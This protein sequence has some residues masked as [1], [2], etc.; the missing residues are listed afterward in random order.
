MAIKGQKAQ[1]THGA[2]Q[3]RHV[4]DDYPT[5]PGFILPLLAR[6]DL[7]KTDVLWDP[8][9][10]GGHLA[11]VL[12]DSGYETKA[13]DIVYSGDDFLDPTKDYGTSDWVITN[14]PFKLGEAF[15]RKSLSVTTKGVAMLMNASFIETVGRIE[16]LYTE[17][18]PSLLLMCHRK[19]IMRDKTHSMFSHVWIIWDKTKPYTGTS[20]EYLR[21]DKAQNLVMPSGVVEGF[22]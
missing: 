12:R 22:W 16:G 18:P 19:M 4:V 2:S 11:Q 14:P 3:E 21:L 7:P 20:F 10:G 5:P 17:F 1:Y 13:N 15:V 9:A 8:C 6:L